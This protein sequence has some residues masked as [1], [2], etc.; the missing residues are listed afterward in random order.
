MDMIHVSKVK[1]I[2][3]LCYGFISTIA[4]QSDENSLLDDDSLKPVTYFGSIAAGCIIFFFMM[5]ILYLA[6]RK[7]IGTA[8][9]WN[10]GLK[11]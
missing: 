5:L 2:F 3:T 8:S 11:K 9:K 4:G 10:T 1:L 6:M 7:E